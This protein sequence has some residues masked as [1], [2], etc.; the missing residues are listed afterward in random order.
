M[1]PD[2]PREK[3]KI[4][5]FWNKYLIAKNQEL[6]GF[7]GTLPAH[8]N[9][10]GHQWALNRADGTGDNQPYHQIEGLMTVEISE[11]PSLT[12]DKIREKLDKIADDM[13][14]QISQGM[15]AEISRVTKEVGNEVNAEGQPLSQGLF[16]QMLEKMDLDF[17]ENGNWNPPTI[18]MHPDL[19]KPRKMKSNLGKPTMNF[20]QSKKK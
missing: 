14:R 12:P 7:F 16:L 13:A 20:F 6:L 9:H 17:D 11:V 1:I 18:V 3:E 8:M 4:M 5:H 15:I 19:W 2:F 10:E